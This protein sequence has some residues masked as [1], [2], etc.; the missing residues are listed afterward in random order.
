MIKKVNASELGIIPAN[1]DTGIKVVSLNLL[2]EDEN[3]P[4]IWRGPLIAGIVEQ[5]WTDVIW[6]N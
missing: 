1:T 6:E 3:Q 4:V 5:F 2:M